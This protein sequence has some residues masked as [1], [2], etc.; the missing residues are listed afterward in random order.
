MP[1]DHVS[2]QDLSRDGNLGGRLGR[3]V[4]GGG[5]ADENPLVEQGLHHGEPQDR[6]GQEPFGC[7]DDNPFDTRQLVEHESPER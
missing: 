2:L 3:S 1:A 7:Q 4:E 6:K 5:F